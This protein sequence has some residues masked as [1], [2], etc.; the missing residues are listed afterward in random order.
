MIP[1]PSPDDLARDA[2]FDYA[3][4]LPRLSFS[5]VESIAALW[6]RRCQAAEAEVTRLTELVAG[7]AAIER[8]ACAQVAEGC[9]VFFNSGQVAAAI[10][11]RGKP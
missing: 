11:E 3:Y 7:T 5:Q 6:L 4:L 1:P 10:R 8:E 2:Q 9:K